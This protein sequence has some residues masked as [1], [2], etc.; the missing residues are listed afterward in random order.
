MT[1]K[2]IGTLSQ[3][4]GSSFGVEREEDSPFPEDESYAVILVG[5]NA[6]RDRTIRTGYLCLAD[7]NTETPCDYKCAKCA[8]GRKVKLT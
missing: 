5:R 8:N 1:R 3:I 2:K 7:Y 4:A 6:C